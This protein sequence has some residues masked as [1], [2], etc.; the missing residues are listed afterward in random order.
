MKTYQAGTTIKF[1][2]RVTDPAN[3]D[4]FIDPDGLTFSGTTI[5]NFGTLD[6]EMVSS[7]S[8]TPTGVRYSPGNYLIT[9]SGITATTPGDIE[10]F[11]I[12]GE[13][14]SEAWD[15]FVL[16]VGI[17][18]PF[19]ALQTINDGVKNASLLIPHSGTV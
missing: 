8:T 10:V 9:F 18:P 7:P 19:S 2:L 5:T 6:V 11:K 14:S 17:T 4:S 1:L 16:E 12:D 15:T 13:I 3:P